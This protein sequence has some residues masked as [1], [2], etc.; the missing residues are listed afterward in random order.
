MGN[1]ALT[2]KKD[3]ERQRETKR[4]KERQHRSRK[5][6]Q[7]S[8]VSTMHRRITEKHEVLLCHL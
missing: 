8:I 7:V 1:L 3:R 6:V 2:L 5:A 4:D